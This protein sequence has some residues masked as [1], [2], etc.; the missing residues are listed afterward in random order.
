M[1]G[2][3][4]RQPSDWTTRKDAAEVSVVHY[5]RYMPT[6]SINQTLFE[7]SAGQTVVR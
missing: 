4:E 5:L 6:D 7:N 3:A 2:E 1:R